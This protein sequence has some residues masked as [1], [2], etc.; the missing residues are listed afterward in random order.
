M[1]LRSLAL[2]LLCLKFSYSRSEDHSHTYI[3]KSTKLSIFEKYRTNLCA[4]INIDFILKTSIMF[5]STIYFLLLIMFFYQFLFLS[6]LHFLYV[7]FLMYY[8]F[9]PLNTH[10]VDLIMINISFIIIVG[11]YMS[12]CYH[13]WAPCLIFM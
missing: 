6:G 7:Q 5:T 13:E 4:R 10:K 3:V 8:I 2:A 12:K 11:P 9:G 1:L